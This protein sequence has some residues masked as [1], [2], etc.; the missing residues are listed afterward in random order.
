MKCLWLIAL[1]AI[2][3]FA[4]AD[5]VRVVSYDAAGGKRTGYGVFLD[6]GGRLATARSLLIGA[7][8]VEVIAGGAT[9]PVRWILCDEPVMGVVQ[10]W[11]E[12]AS[13]ASAFGDELPVAPKTARDVP[14]SGLVLSLGNEVKA[15]SAG[16][17]VRDAEGRAVAMLLPQFLGTR[18]VAFAIPL[19]RI[20]ALPAQPIRSLEE[21]A[22]ERVT[23]AEEAYVLGLGQVWAEQYDRAARSLAEAVQWQPGYPEAWFHLGFA[24]GKTGRSKDRVAAYDKAIAL[25][26]DFAEAHY[27]LGISLL[28]MGRRAEALGEVEQ[29]RRIPTAA[30]LAAK[31]AT[32]IEAAHVD[33]ITHE[34]L[35]NPLI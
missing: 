25:K 15:E 27:S 1:G 7:K 12:G 22:A 21:W 13:E 6:N 34:H 8:R 32:L 35:K 23:A 24:L 18:H 30:T 9:R 29:L 5:D 20:R 16:E 3:A 26:P 2:G 17:L 19:F 28:L 14:G 11:V 33:D 10:L 4:A 31:L